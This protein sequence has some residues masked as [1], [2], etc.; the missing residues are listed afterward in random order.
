MDADQIIARQRACFQSGATR[1]LQFRLAQLQKLHDAVESGEQLLFEALQKDLRK[2]PQDAYT[3]EIGLV[4]CEIRHA[5]RH[6]RAWMKPR[7]R[8]TP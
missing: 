8:R 2:S 3:T 1:P 6:L 5:I 7:R 4:L